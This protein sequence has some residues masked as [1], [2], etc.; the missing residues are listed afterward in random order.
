MDMLER[1]ES[2]SQNYVRTPRIAFD[3]AHGAELFDE[4]GNRYV[5]FFAGG[6]SLSYGHNNPAVRSA[7]ID[8]LS[9]GRAL[10]TG[11]R[12]SIAKR[13]FVE[14][15]V[16]AILEP[17]KLNYRLLF[18]D[19][20]GGAA[21]ETALRL[22]RRHRN[23]ANVVAFTNASHGVTEGALAITSKQQSRQVLG[24][25]NTV[26][27]P[28]CGYFG[29]E[30]DTIAYFRRYLRD[31]SSGLDLPAAA[32]VETTQ[33]H[34]GVHIAS[35]E[36]LKKLEQL[37]REYEILLVIDDTHTG[38]GRVGPY[39]SFEAAGITPDI[40]IGSNAMAAGLPLSML[41]L[42][43]ELDLWRPGEQ[44]G[45]FQGDSLAFVAATELLS[46]WNCNLR[47]ELERNAGVLE[48]ELSQWPSLYKPKV[49]VRGH[50]MVWALDFQRPGS[51][52]V[53]SAWA[54]ER[55]LV[56]EAAHLHDEV[57]LV[58]PPLIIDEATLLRGLN[59]L[60]QVV[61]T[62]LSYPSGARDFTQN[63]S[64]GHKS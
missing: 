39:F 25:A 42:K 58:M 3:K 18:T 63:A 13:Q 22:A 33:V 20:A 46:Q 31:T 45:A 23:R 55:G 52:A 5:D 17:R 30:T 47:A 50:G 21:A 26:F 41:L 56:V 8:Y 57:V 14:L 11:H 28:F 15:F 40:V 27:M 2:V 43:P 7:L 19:P 53:I 36:W 9:S 60:R 44:A 61:S 16:T 32:I 48:A 35:P 51:A 38:C 10:Q 54:L 37:C 49:S 24:K 6:G 62:F 34:G 64:I 1:F 29:S 4:A 12:T 59:R